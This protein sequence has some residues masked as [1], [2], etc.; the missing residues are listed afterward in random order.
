M[1][2]RIVDLV[3]FS[4]FVHQTASRVVPTVNDESVD[5]VWADPKD[6]PEPLHPGVRKFLQAHDSQRW[7]AKDRTPIAYSELG[8]DQR[9][10]LDE[11]S[12]RNYDRTGRLHVDLSHLTKANICP[13]FGKEIP[14]CEGLGLDPNRI[15][16]LLR[17][18]GELEKA[19]PTFNG[20][21]FLL[22]HK[23][24][25]ADDHPTDL[26]IGSTGTGAVWNEPYIDNGIVIWPG[27]AI[28]D[29]ETAKKKQLSAGYHYKADMTPGVWKGTPYDGVMR[30]IVGNHVAMVKDGRAGDDVVVGDEALPK[31]VLEAHNPLE[32]NMSKTLLSRKA[33]T[34]AGARFSP[35]SVLVW[36][37]TPRS[38]LSPSSQG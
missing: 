6:P 12:V 31:E 7:M 22:R 35:R 15:Y 18:P 23:P 30:N 27:N 24:T 25:S 17:D 13:Y 38:T 9:L 10:A 5:A 14:G 37:W 33:A 20:L 32:I 1:I 16:N 11:G 36:R 19:V 34:V 2:G 3:D 29:V 4:T 28:K 21:P 26:V 8:E